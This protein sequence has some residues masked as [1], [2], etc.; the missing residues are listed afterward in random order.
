MTITLK[1]VSLIKRVMKNLL[2]I[3]QELRNTKF[4]K[5]K[6]KSLSGNILLSLLFETL[7]YFLDLN[8]RWKNCN[9]YSKQTMF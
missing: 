3:V 7:I 2:G 1:F 5:F 4:N 8:F 6:K 9:K